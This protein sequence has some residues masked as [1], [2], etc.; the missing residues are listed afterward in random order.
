MEQPRRV[1]MIV[2]GGL[3]M[4]AMLR[5]VEGLF[6]IGRP[7]RRARSP[8]DEAA[9][10]A[11]AACAHRFC[12]RLR[13]T[14]DDKLTFAAVLVRAGEVHAAA[15]LVDEVAREVRAQKG[16]LARRV[17]VVGAQ[18]AV[19]APRPGKRSGR[20]WPPR[21]RLFAA[22]A[23][24][25][26]VVVAAFVALVLLTRGDALDGSSEARPVAGAGVPAVSE[27]D[28]PSG[29]EAGR[30]GLPD[31][32]DAA[33]PG[34]GARGSSVRFP[35]AGRGGEGAA[36]AGREPSKAASAA[37]PPGGTR[38]SSSDGPNR[39][40]FGDAPEQRSASPAR[41]SSRSGAAPA[42]RRAREIALDPFDAPAP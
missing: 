9:G 23:V 18:R 35:S 10:F 20:G 42:L 30:G 14:A 4:A 12:R 17:E 7:G 21:T 31:G 29:G 33:G 38:A 19:A 16:A 6:G 22:G 34:D 28:G 1:E 37:L 15:Q 3:E 27:G 5:R 13:D 11:L 24:G 36:A 40:S 26:V 8:E 25:L 2:M 32:R 39:G 41:T